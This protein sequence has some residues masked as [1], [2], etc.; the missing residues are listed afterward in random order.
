VKGLPQEWVQ[1]V[2]PVCVIVS[3]RPPISW[4]RME[5][6]YWLCKFFTALQTSWM[7]HIGLFLP[8]VTQRVW[9]K[10]NTNWRF[11]YCRWFV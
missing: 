4:I 5:Q 8:H 6:Q 11:Y 7:F 3:S 10:L 1:I 9:T 2:H